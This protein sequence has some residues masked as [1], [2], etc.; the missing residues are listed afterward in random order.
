MTE[1]LREIGLRL[2][3]LRSIAEM[4]AE[5]FCE[6]VGVTT[7]VLAAYEKGEL[8]F[9]FSFLYNAARIL[10]VDVVDLMS[11]DSPHL[12]DWCIVRNGEGYAIDRRAAYKY[13]HLAFT[14]RKKKAEPFLVTVEPKG[15]K[16]VQHAHD[17]QE[18]NWLVSGRMCFFI[19]DK[20]YVL[21][22]GDSVYFNASIPHAMQALD[23]S[24]AQFLAV[25]MG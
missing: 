1:Q 19:A 18:F 3:A 17:G 22:P 8:D 5:V 10:G 23:N 24:P 20:E 21:E 16:P 14:F 25:V 15:D 11:G 2:S 7:E 4:T 13:N 12:S 9:S 6:K